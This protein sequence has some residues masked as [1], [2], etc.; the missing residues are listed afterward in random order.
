MQDSN[1]QVFIYY[2]NGKLSDKSTT[3]PVKKKEKRIHFWKNSLEI[4]KINLVLEKF[5]VDS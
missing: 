3:G 4:R 5:S 2:R 1:H